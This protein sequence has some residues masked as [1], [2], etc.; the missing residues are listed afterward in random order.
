MS[1]TARNEARGPALA[2]SAAVDLSVLRQVARDAVDDL[3]VWIDHGCATADD[4][5]STFSLLQLTAVVIQPLALDRS[6][7]YLGEHHRETAAWVA[8]LA[9]PSTM[10]VVDESP[11]AERSVLAEGSSASELVVPDNTPD[12]STLC[13]SAHSDLEMEP[14]LGSEEPRQLTLMDS[15]E[16]IADLAFTYKRRGFDRAWLVRD[17]AELDLVA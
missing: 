2:R 4:I 11:A 17:S 16:G 10:A 9:T 13:E 15:A 5:L 3:E 7:E 14:L 8:T 12:P 6:K 1:E